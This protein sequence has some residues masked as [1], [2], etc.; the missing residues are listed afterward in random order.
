M[1]V[2]ECRP[3][4]FWY[5]LMKNGEQIIRALGIQD[6]IP[7]SVDTKISEENPESWSERIPNANMAE[8]TE[9]HARSGDG[10]TKYPSGPYPHDNDHS[11]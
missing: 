9:G 10:R 11:T 2:G 3:E 7:C 8:D 1:P 6:R 5:K 4:I